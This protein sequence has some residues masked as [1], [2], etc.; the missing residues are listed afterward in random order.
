[1]AQ[2][3]SAGAH[4]TMSRHLV[5]SCIAIQAGIQDQLHLLSKDVRAL[6]R[7]LQYSVSFAQVQNLPDGGLSRQI[8]FSRC[9]IFGLLRGS[10]TP[11]PKP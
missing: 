1:M 6:L 2:E 10:E 11:L 9:D 8:R 5:W 4:L 7:D 3:G